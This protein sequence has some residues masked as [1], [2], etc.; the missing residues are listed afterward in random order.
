[1]KM[2]QKEF[3]DKI[4]RIDGFARAAIV[5]LS[6][7]KRSFNLAGCD[8]MSVARGML[9]PFEVAN[10]AYEIAEQAELARGNMIAKM[11]VSCNSCPFFSIISGQSTMK[12]NHSC[13]PCGGFVIDYSTYS[14]GKISKQCP[15]KS[16]D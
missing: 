3:G 14:S 12:C 9:S 13:A 4:A 2:S 5:G 16:S 11:V 15:M 7:A 6:H 8:G 1:M 10:R